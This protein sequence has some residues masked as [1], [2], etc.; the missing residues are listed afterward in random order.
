LDGGENTA[1]YTYNA[2]GQ[3]IADQAYEVSGGA[4]RL[5]EQLHYRALHK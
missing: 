1:D 2:I 3:V 4:A 5:N